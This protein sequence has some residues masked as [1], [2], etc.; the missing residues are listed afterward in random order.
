MA[1]KVETRRGICETHGSVE[2][3]REMPRT[4][5]P[6][7]VYAVRR[8]MARKR[9]FLCPSCGKPVERH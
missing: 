3:T 8:F 6:F 2:A 5:F 9:P 1:D 7:I 4:Q